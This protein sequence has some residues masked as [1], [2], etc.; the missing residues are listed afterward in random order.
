[1]R[2]SLAGDVQEMTILTPW[3]GAGLYGCD[4]FEGCTPHSLSAHQPHRH[5][6]E[7]MVVSQAAVLRSLSSYKYSTIHPC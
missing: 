4:D 3:I 5:C 7:I 1:M 6:V 2:G